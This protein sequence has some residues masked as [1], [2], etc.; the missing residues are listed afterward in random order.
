MQYIY[1]LTLYG[2]KE[3]F[4]KLSNLQTIPVIQIKLD[5]SKPFGK[6]NVQINQIIVG[7]IE[8]ASTRKK[9]KAFSQN[10]LTKK[11]KY[12]GHKGPV[13]C[14]RT[15]GQN[16]FLYGSDD[17]SILLWEIKTAMLNFELGLNYLVL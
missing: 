5:L 16:H 9:I 7:N 12:K 11:M 17:G 4:Y 10:H 3:L 14:L 6:H 1:F 8:V 2:F 15:S 13:N